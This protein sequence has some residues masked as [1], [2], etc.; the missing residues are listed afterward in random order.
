METEKINIYKN[1]LTTTEAESLMGELLLPE[2]IVWHNDLTSTKNGELVKIKRKMAY[3][4]DDSASTYVYASLS[5]LGQGWIESLA[6]I[7]D[8]LN[9]FTGRNFNSVLLNWYADGKE[10]IG[11]HSDKE[12]VLGDI[13]TS[14]I[15]CVNMGATRKFWYRKIEDNSEKLFYSLEAGDLLMMNAGF[16]AEY[17]H[18]ILKEPEILEPRISLTFREIY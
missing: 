14:V 5:F 15:A 9:K 1:F 8:N 2:N 10:T 16:Q 18:A 6:S 17:L 12:E 7:R 11:W 3:V 13:N 4:S